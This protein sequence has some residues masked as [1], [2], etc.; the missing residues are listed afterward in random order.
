MQ[1][2]N[3]L[4]CV[5]YSELVLGAERVLNKSELYKEVSI[6][7]SSR[8]ILFF[9]EKLEFFKL[10]FL[11]SSLVMLIY[12]LYVIYIPHVFFL[13]CLGD[14]SPQAFDMMGKN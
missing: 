8:N 10:F 13:F 11:V 3:E 5:K 12:S 6:I 9:N 14:H 7:R 2:L 1:G 4:I